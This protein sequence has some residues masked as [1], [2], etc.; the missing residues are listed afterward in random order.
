M[1]LAC[2]ARLDA[3]TFE[4]IVMSC[5]QSAFKVS[6]KVCDAEIKLLL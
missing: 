5:D 2:S 1:V 4:E 3:A 6:T